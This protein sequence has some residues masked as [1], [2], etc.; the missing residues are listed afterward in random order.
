MSK[1]QA[2][3]ARC[4]GARQVCDR[5]SGEPHAPE[6]QQLKGI[7]LFE[8]IMTEQV[9]DKLRDQTRFS[10]LSWNAR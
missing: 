8:E 5:E 10:I 9:S 4:T 3:E 1:K 6:E 2:F 7:R